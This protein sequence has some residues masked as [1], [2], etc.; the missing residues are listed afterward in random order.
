M[1]AIKPQNG[2]LLRGAITLNI[3]GFVR[4]KDDR[5]AAPAQQLRHFGVARVRASCGV[6][7]EQDQVG[8]VNSDARLILHP[9]L[10]RIANGGLHAARVHHTK[11]HSIPLNDAD[12]PIAGGTGTILYDCTALA[13]E[14]IEEGALPDVGSPN[15]RHKWQATRQRLGFGLC[16]EL[17]LTHAG[18]PLVIEV[19]RYCGVAAASRAARAMDAAFVRT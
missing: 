17:F 10:N 3:V 6:N 1:K 8:G 19:V 18:A 11:A 9:N 2:E 13:N 4:H 5:L 14:A 7:K 15:E 16:L 12:Q